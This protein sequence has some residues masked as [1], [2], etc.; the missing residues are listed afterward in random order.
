MKKRG[1]TQLMA[2]GAAT[3]CCVIAV[4]SVVLARGGGAAVLL[5][6]MQKTDE[7][8]PYPLTFQNLMTVLFG[9]AIGDVLHR[10]AEVAREEASVRQQLLPEDDRT[11]LLVEDLRHVRARVLAAKGSGP[12]AFLHELL[13][14]CVLQYQANRQVSGSH[15]LM[16]SMVDLEMHRVDLRYTFLRY[17]AWLIPTLGFIGT[18]TGIAI[19]LARLSEGDGGSPDM[20]PVLAGLKTAFNSTILALIQ[21]AVVVYLLQFT[22]QREEQAVNA[23]S[24]YC[25]RNLINRLYSPPSGAQAAGAPR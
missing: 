20:G 5:L 10:R 2:L 1:R 23:A 14:Q 11:V 12:A 4:L 6:D 15:E 8:L 9:A 16:A 25:V 21:S 3:A 13:D 24:T 19:A 17:V 22:Q 7:M 18:V